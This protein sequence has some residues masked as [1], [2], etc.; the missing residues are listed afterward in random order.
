MTTRTTKPTRP[1]SPA[2][3]HT[4]LTLHGPHVRQLHQRVL[5]ITGLRHGEVQ[6]LCLLRELGSCPGRLGCSSERR[7][8]GDRD[9]RHGQG[10]GTSHTADRRR[11]NKLPPLTH[12]TRNASE[13]EPTERMPPTLHVP[14]TDGTSA[15][16]NRTMG[17]RG[18]RCSLPYA[19]PVTHW[20]AAATTAG[21]CP[22]SRGFISV[23]ELR[24]LRSNCLRAAFTILAACIQS[25]DEQPHDSRAR[26][27]KQPP[28]R[29]HCRARCPSLILSTQTHLHNT[30]AQPRPVPKVF[31]HLPPR[32]PTPTARTRR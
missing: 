18:Y 32:L 7:V 27:G 15:S 19:E 26:G 2:H 6:L 3:T 12:A 20:D 8:V 9:S 17:W 23:V 10:H 25:P 16:P 30:T 5:Q 28:G 24:W 22:S 4:H 21:V 13:E 1:R 31:L 29:R 11:E 14:Y